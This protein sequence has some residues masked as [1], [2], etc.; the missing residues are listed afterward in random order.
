MPLNASPRVFKRE[1]LQIEAIRSF[2]QSVILSNIPLLAW[3][4][5]TLVIS[6]V[7]AKSGRVQRLE[8]MVA[9]IASSHAAISMGI[10]NIEFNPSLLMYLPGAQSHHGNGLNRNERFENVRDFLRANPASDVAGKHV[11][12]IDD[13]VTSGASLIYSDIYLRAAGAA[14]VTLLALT[15]NVG[16]G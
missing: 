13:V 5:E 9:Q 16:N 15:K 8:A 11:V 7:P 10:E 14:S 6:V 4:M 12:V 1:P 2:I 3:G